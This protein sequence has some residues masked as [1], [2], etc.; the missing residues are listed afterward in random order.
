[1]CPPD[2]VLPPEHT[3]DGMTM[4]T[5][6]TPLVTGGV[7]A[8]TDTHHAA[9]LDGQGRLL[10]TKAFATTAR[11]Y[12]ELADWLEGHGEVVRVGVESTG[13]YAAALVRTLA[14]RGIPI[15]EVNQP[16]PHARARRGKSDP[17]DAELAARAALAGTATAT[18][19]TTTGV[20][21]AIRQLVVARDG[22]M[23]ART[24]ALGQ[25]EDLV[26][27]APVELRERLAC[28]RTLRGKATLCA[29]LQPDLARIA[30]PREALKLA[31]RGLAQ[32][33]MALEVEIA[34]LD[35]QLQ[36]LVAAAAPRTTSL[37]GVSTGHASQLL[38]S[39]GQNIERLR[40]EAA[41]AKLCAAAPKPASSGR[42]TRHRLDTGGDRQA[43]RTLHLI[44]VCRLRYC[45]RTRAYA[46][47]RTAEGLSKREIIRCLKRYIAREVYATLRDDLRSLSIP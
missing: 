24:A 43:N 20:V 25:I 13:S 12:R 29:K 3:K 17:L 26:L 22:A 32:R 6:L 40:S 10:G 7:D 33:V 15:V 21:E 36:T 19:K 31:L 39:A 42:T 28:R 34:A 23:K 14:T 4:M 47:R 45:E 1:L 46:V 18:P 44:A 2:P 9:V 5:S 16:H 11:G 8:H 27:T 35:T 37:L 41:F 38:V 30:H